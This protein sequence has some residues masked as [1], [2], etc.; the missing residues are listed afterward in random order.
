[1]RS[2]YAQ[3]RMTGLIAPPPKKIT[4]N[5]KR[6]KIS[7]S[8]G[9]PQFWRLGARFQSFWPQIRIQP[10]ELFQGQILMWFWGRFCSFLVCFLCFPMFLLRFAMFYYVFGMF[11][12]V[13]DMFCYVFKVCEFSWKKLSGLRAVSSGCWKATGR[14]TIKRKNIGKH[15]ETQQNIANT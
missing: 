13:F 12:Y 3:K 1:M 9:F 6:L 15:T 8:R 4:T 2:R 10:I 14:P 7:H 5:S 11:G